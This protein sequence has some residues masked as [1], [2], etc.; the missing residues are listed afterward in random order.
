MIEKIGGRKF[1]F[2]ILISIVSS[3]ALI[4][5]KITFKEWSDFEIVIGG[6]YI[7]G[8]VGSKLTSVIK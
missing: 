5:G 4:V 8:N 3:I 1:I 2:S 7:L 6:L